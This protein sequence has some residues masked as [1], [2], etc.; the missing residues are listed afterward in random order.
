[1]GATAKVRLET[2][3]QARF[4]DPLIRQTETGCDHSQQI[5]SLQLRGNDVCTD[6]VFFWQELKECTDERGLSGADITR[7]DY[8][9]F[10]LPDSVAQI[11]QSPLV[12]AA[13]EKKA[14]IGAQAERLGFEIVKGFV[15]V[16]TAFSPCF[17]HLQC[18]TI[19]VKIRIQVV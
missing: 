10:A 5:V 15:H 3:Q 2:S 1:M 19:F 17:G 12:A 4:A 13:A 7:N 18:H 11:R 9:A 14:R 16:R 8:E 6:D